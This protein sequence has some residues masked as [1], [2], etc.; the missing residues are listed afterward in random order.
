V[1]YDLD[2]CIFKVNVNNDDVEQHRRHVGVLYVMSKA[3]EA[4]R[5]KVRVADFHQYR[6]DAHGRRNIRRL[7]KDNVKYGETIT[8]EGKIIES[9]YKYWRKFL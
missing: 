8:N 4:R 1:N 9:T 3:N 6:Y 7:K 5:V 2:N